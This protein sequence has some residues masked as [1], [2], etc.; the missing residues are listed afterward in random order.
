MLTITLAV[1]DESL[2]VNDD[3]SNTWDIGHC[4]VKPYG[5]ALDNRDGGE[6]QTDVGGKSVQYD[7]PSV[8]YS[9][10]FLFLD[11]TVTHIVRDVEMATL[12][13]VAVAIYVDALAADRAMC[14]KIRLVHSHIFEGLFTEVFNQVLSLAAVAYPK[15]ICHNEQEHG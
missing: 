2:A 3:T 12:A 5:V 1:T 4:V 10:G 11:M 7:F 15:S 9:L 14:R 6:Y 13:L 8:Q